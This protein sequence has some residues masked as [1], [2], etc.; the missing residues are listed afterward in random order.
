MCVVHKSLL[1]VISIGTIT[2]CVYSCRGCRILYLQIVAFKCWGEN[3]LKTVNRLTV[4][5][6][7][8]MFSQTWQGSHLAWLL[9]FF[10]C[11]GEAPAGQQGNRRT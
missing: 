3:V 4:S 7:V 6:I 5:K 11:T 8:M 10:Q 2:L 1:P 9:L